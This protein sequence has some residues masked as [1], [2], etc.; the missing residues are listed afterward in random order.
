MLNLNAKIRDP[1]DSLDFIRKNGDLPAVFYSAGKEPTLISISKNE[2]KKV[3]WGDVTRKNA[4]LMKLT[5][6]NGN[7]IKLTP[8]HKVYTDSGWKEA[9]DLTTNDKILS[10]NL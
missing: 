6:K 2:F 5:D 9:K 3:V 1:K 7:E 4:K 10:L 8:D